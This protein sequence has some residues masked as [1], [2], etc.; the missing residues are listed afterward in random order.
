MPTWL[1]TGGDDTFPD[2]SAMPPQFNTAE[3]VVNGFGGNDT[4]DGGAMNDS[5]HG[6][7]GSD[8]IFGGTGND[9]ITGDADNDHLFGDDGDDLLVD[10]GDGNDDVQG[11][12]G[13]DL[14][15]GGQGSDQVFGGDGNDQIG[16]AVHEQGEPQAGDHDL[17][18]GEAGDDVLETVDLPNGATASLEGGTGTNTVRSTGSLAG[19]TFTNVQ[20]LENAYQIRATTAQINQFAS[21][22]DSYA[23]SDQTDIFLTS[24]G[25][26][27]FAT[28]LAPGLK[29]HVFLNSALG[30]TVIGGPNDDRMEVPIFNPAGGAV[31]LEGGGGNDTLLGG[32]RNDFFEGGP[33]NDY[34]YG[35]RASTRRATHTRQPA[36]W[37]RWRTRPRRTRS[38]PGSI[39]STSA[40]SRL[41]SALPTTMC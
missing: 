40:R 24:G 17:Y 10:G 15:V 41:C 32:A 12:I 25:A 38:A 16:A 9:I 37:S 6:D 18:F 26:V 35:S 2:G 31:H 3:D 13:N 28:R 39:R 1:L 20:V 36:S 34:I 33:G 22:T 7:Q 23:G 14:L 11:G 29:L 21:I 4:I 19:Y 27:N 8:T 30:N 5:L